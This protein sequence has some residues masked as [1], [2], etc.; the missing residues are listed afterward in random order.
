LY[1]PV[2]SEIEELVLGEIE[3]LEA[4][5]LSDSMGEVDKGRLKRE[6]KKERD[7]E[8]E[9]I[10]SSERKEIFLF[11]YF[12]SLLLPHWYSHQQVAVRREI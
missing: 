6:E 1:G 7:E 9:E 4:A 10:L 2:R 12:L 11:S 3:E 8:W 5:A